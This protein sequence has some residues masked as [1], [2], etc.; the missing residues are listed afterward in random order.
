GGGPLLAST[1]LAHIGFMTKLP[2]H[3]RAGAR[4]HLIRRWRAADAIRVIAEQRIPS[5]G[6]IPAQIA[7]ILRDPALDDHDLSC[8][9]AI[10]AGGG[11]SSPA[12]VREAR[13]RFRAPYSIRYSSTESGG[14]GTATAFDAPDEEAFY[15]VGRPRGGTHMP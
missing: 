12:L 15:T 7:L 1:E 6:G 14:V 5:I 2:W 3:F 8:V 4:I 10:V 13:D 9:K 11:P